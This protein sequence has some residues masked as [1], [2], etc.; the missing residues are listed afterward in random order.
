[1]IPESS[2][3]K[4]IKE[5]PYCELISLL[6]ETFHLNLKCIWKERDLKKPLREA[7]WAGIP[8]IK[9][10]ISWL[11][12]DVLTKEYITQ[13]L[14]NEETH[15]WARLSSKIVK[16]FIVHYTL[17][18]EQVKANDNLVLFRLISNHHSHCADWLIHR[19]GVTF[20][21]VVTMMNRWKRSCSFTGDLRTWQLLLRN[22]PSL[23]PDV[24][25]DHLMLLALSSPATA[26]FVLRTFPTITKADMTD[27][28]LNCAHGFSN[29]TRL[30]LDVPRLRRF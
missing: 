21:E 19:F 6:L 10:L 11:G 4:V 14:T 30:W 28:A 24:V 23:T 9:L 1:M 20:T 7:V 13:F 15:Q 8:N 5:S 26:K 25:R 2:V 12:E 3:V 18:N 22:F 17:E 27:Y 29:E 16:W